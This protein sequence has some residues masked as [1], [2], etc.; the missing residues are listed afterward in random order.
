V[1]P[2][3]RYHI[4]KVHRGERSQ[5]GRF[6]EFYQCDID[7]VGSNSPIV[8]AEFPAIIS[9]IFTEFAF[10]PF[11]IR[12]N[13]RRILNGFFESIGLASQKEVIMRLVDKIEKMSEE[14]FRAKLADVGLDKAQSD[15]LLDFVNVTGT[16]DEVIS[17]LI[18]FEI[19]NS[20]F[21]AGLQNMKN[22][23]AATRML[24]VPAA[25]FV[26]DLK[27]ARGLDYYTGTVY[28]TMLVN[29]PGLGS[30]CSGG[31]FDN[32]A[33]LYIDRNLP[34]VG[35]SIGLSRLFYKL[36]ELGVIKSGQK[37]PAKVIVIPMSENEFAYAVKVAGAIRA[38]NVSVLSYTEVQPFKKKMQ[39][40]DKMGFTYAAVIGEREVAEGAVSVKNLATGETV[41][42]KLDE[43]FGYLMNS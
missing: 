6:R 18:S 43:D 10:G 5:A 31:R 7:V 36:R 26:I 35:V 25:N 3:R 27:I 34:G 33:G 30:V 19:D 37:S 14:D 13:D 42:K 40:A 29:H 8:D 15:K 16:N 4:G 11:I 1:F 41:I 38:A 20:D 22:I 39:Y 32:L 12:V 28:E 2:F 23:V 24:G 21:E 17:K 9:E